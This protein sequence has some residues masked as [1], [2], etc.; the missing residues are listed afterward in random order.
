MGS[1]WG[2]MLG[3]YDFSWG[4]VGLDRVGGGSLGG[5]WDGI[6]RK[7]LR[8]ITEPNEKNASALPATLPR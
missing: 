4:I 3:L 5:E 6:G 2:S 7:G 1:L 8:R